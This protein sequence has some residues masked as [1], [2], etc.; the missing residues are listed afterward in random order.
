M[1]AA[2]LAPGFALANPSGGQIV[3]GQVSISNPAAN[4]TLVNQTS[5]SA[6]VNW[7]Q[8]NVAGN[9]YVQFV[10]PS[11]S[12]VILNRVIGGAPS[13]IFGSMRANGRV[14]L[15]NPQGVLFAPGAQVDVGALVAST[16]D[17][18]NED[19]LAGR[20]VFSGGT[21]G[22]GVT[23]AGAVTAADGGFV[24]LQGDY[25]HNTGIVQAK[26]GQ[27]VLASGSA[28]TLT[29]N[30]NGLVSFAVDAAAVSQQAGVSNAGDIIADGGKV[31]MTAKV[32][33]GLVGTAVNN[34]G[35]VSAQ[36]IVEHD[37]EIE[38][39]AA[40]GDVVN[41]GTLDAS[42]TA[43]DGGKIDVTS[44]SN[45]DLQSGTQLL[46]S[47]S[48]RGGSVRVIADGD[49]HLRA[50]ASLAATGGVGGGIAELSGH[51]NTVLRGNVSL[52]RGGAL[53]I[54]PATI[55]IADGSGSTSTAN[56]NQTM[57]ETFVEGLLQNGTDVNL[58]ATNSITL[59]ALTDG[60]LDGQN[61]NGLPGGNLF[62]GIGTGSNAASFVQ[63]GG[64]TIGFQNPTNNILLGGTFT[65]RGGT[66]NGTVTIGSVSATGI[67]IKSA[68]NI[69]TG[70]L[71]ATRGAVSVISSQGSGSVGDVSASDIS[72]SGNLDASVTL[73]AATGLQVGNIF[74]EAAVTDGS[75]DANASVTLSTTSGNINVTGGIDTRA[76][77]SGSNHTANGT[78]TLTST[79]GNITT[80][81]DIDSAA[82]GNAS[83]LNDVTISTGGNVTTGAINAYN[84]G[85]SIAGNNLTV[86]AL[87]GSSSDG[88]TGT[89]THLDIDAKGTLTH[90]D[91]DIT[92][93]RISLSVGQGD[94]TFG[95]L[96]SNDGNLSVTAKGGAIR[97]G[98]I[99]TFDSTFGSNADASVKLTAA[100]GIS[101]GGI[102]T[103]AS[104][105]GQGVTADASVTLTTAAGP[106]TVTDPI[107]ANA[108]TYS[109]SGGPAGTAT[110]SVSITDSGGAITTSSISSLASGSGAIADDITI[111]ASGDV[112]TGDLITASG[113]ITVSGHNLSLGSL[114]GTGTSSSEQTV[115][116][117]TLTHVTLDA[118]GTLD[119]S[120][121]G[122]GLTAGTISLRSGSGDI[123][124]SNLDATTGGL[125]ITAAGNITASTGSAITANAI[126][127]QAGG[128]INLA[129]ATLNIGNGA[130]DF[131][132]DPAL[133][134]AIR[135]DSK[136]RN[137]TLP[138][139]SSPNGAF[140]AQSVQLGT[141]NLGGGYLFVQADSH[142]IG[143]VNGPLDAA[144]HPTTLLNL[145]P[146]T[147]QSDWTIPTTVQQV[148]GT[149]ATGLTA[150]A[151]T[152][153]TAPTLT[154]PPGIGTVAFG[155][156]SFASNIILPPGTVVSPD[157]TN[158]VFATQGTISNAGALSIP[159]IVVL[160]G[161]TL[162]GLNEIPL[163]P[164][165][166]QPGFG[167]GIDRWTAP[168]DIY[169]SGVNDSNEGLIEPQSD[170]EAVLVC[171]GAQ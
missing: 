2:A 23:N 45:I 3:A 71:D 79:S 84:A 14:F 160:L 101:V 56:G 36:G 138:P 73:S 68:G 161:R 47:G 146:F 88:T 16:L 114:S 91:T 140:K 137:I 18:K 141:V 152:S 93:N 142:S 135:N 144:N 119:Y 159:G 20:Y 90:A 126:S 69:K 22:A 145:Q 96:D 99:S 13:E 59:A 111:N 170:T 15:V 98:S 7:Q 86:G 39:T 130:A 94:V 163:L 162:D 169:Y 165:N 34:T 51:R 52:G 136:G 85:I 102:S 168:G 78:V 48:A 77:A 127:V 156:S 106:I 25:V 133:L 58:I 8:F 167:H 97:I 67:D 26:L 116:I 115:G 55:T 110:A 4:G 9:E 87:S 44:D 66:T 63:G 132:A 61:P 118:S 89:L 81:G 104:A 28:T 57:Y 134:D 109:E 113:G 80:A 171:G 150:T 64:G 166:Y 21:P 74:T 60:T 27:V 12:A 11:S 129:G 95:T 53:T 83:A 33:R 122:T 42:S 46:A 38:L 103:F 6:I 92:A 72:P 123:D 157:T 105:S 1:G 5:Q 125:S 117:G 124:A 50:G 154:I 82:D 121:A 158:L 128:Q 37:G 17:I 29:L 112:N 164:Q 120:N 54:D 40:G 10:Q 30:D 149:L 24:V 62:M 35:R 155:G 143:Q 70:D 107:S 131:G 65:V 43:G 31:V 147:A 148:T 41:S 100:T 139:S 32:A 19:F 151:A 108:E 76:S 153:S 49:L 75:G